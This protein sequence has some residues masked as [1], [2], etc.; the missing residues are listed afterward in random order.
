MERTVYYS[1]R[2]EHHTRNQKLRMEFINNFLA[3]L[4]PE[5]CVG[6]GIRGLLLC[7]ECKK[8]IEPAT[9]PMCSWIMSIFSYND[10][11]IKRLVRLLKYKNNRGV[12]DIFA[13][14]IASTLT[15]FLG[16]EQL[17]LG[18]RTIAIVPIPL[19]LKR[20]QK[21]GYNQAEL[22]ARKMVEQMTSK[23]IFLETKLLKKIKETIPQAQ[24]KHRGKRLQNLGNCFVSTRK[25][26]GN[27]VVILID[28]VTTTGATVEAARRVLR[29]A[30]FRKIYALTLAH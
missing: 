17:L 18:S 10:F 29:T 25:S 4:F 5:K 22:L 8:K 13:P 3:I 21:R 23:N 20:M 27:E 15:E 30:G 24:I 11:R 28:D 1:S 7:D 2:K 16:E 6:C 14:Y 9:N 19:S 12:A 26:E